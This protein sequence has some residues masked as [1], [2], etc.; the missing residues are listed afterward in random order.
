MVLNYVELT[1]KPNFHKLDKLN[2]INIINLVAFYNY[3]TSNQLV[4]VSRL[5]RNLSAIDA[6][7]PP[8]WLAAIPHFNA[9]TK[10]LKYIFTDIYN[11]CGNIDCVWFI[12]DLFSLNSTKNLV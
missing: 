12:G 4:E 2:L 10:H 5:N 3:I 6:R 11:F 7:R 9:P 1:N 8:F